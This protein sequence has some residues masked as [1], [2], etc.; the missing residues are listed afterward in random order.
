MALTAPAALVLAHYRST[1][2]RATHDSVR[3]ARVMSAIVA[4]IAVAF[5]LPISLMMLHL[6]RR[7]GMSLAEGGDF[8]VLNFWTSMQAILSFVFA[9][10]GSFRLKPAFP[11]TRFGRFP[12]SAL[13]LLLAEFPASVVEVFPILGILGLLFTNAGLAIAMPR[14]APV[15]VLIA[16]DSVVTFVATMFI[17]SALVSWIGGS[18]IA[19]AFA[20]GVLAAAVYFTGLESVRIVINVWFPAIVHALPL[21]SAHEGMIAWYRGQVATGVERVG[22][23]TFATAVLFIIAGAVHHRRVVTE[24]GARG[25]RLSRASAIHFESAA[26]GIGKLFFRQVVTSSVG[27]SVLGISFFITAPLCLVVALGRQAGAEGKV[28]PE[29][30]VRTLDHVGTMP[31]V[32]IVPLFII[33]GFSAQIW[34]NQF[35]FDAGSI[36]GFLAL[37]ITPGDFLLGKAYGLSKYLGVQ[38]ALALIPLVA[39][40][41]PHLRHVIAGAAVAVAGAVVAIALGQVLSLR[42]PRA[43]SASGIGTNLPMYLSWIPMVTAVGLGVVLLGLYAIGEAIVRNAGIVLLIVVAGG[44]CFAYRAAIPRLG[45]WMNVNRERLLTM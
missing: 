14:M 32:A 34:V 4:G 31:W 11:M 29:E 10:L 22:W 43:F 40:P 8:E 9:I 27:R 35:G 13:D 41:R 42:F 20:V 28:L 24:S 25:W 1:W 17:A 30:M 3:G 23:A 12:L 33:V 16:V 2:N 6:S 5:L 45:E 15:I 38:L 36:R 37:P 26:S 18:R 19:T 44:L 39:L 7:T 21:T